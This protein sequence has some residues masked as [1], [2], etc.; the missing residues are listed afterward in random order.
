MNLPP[1][2]AIVSS[3]PPSHFADQQ[4]AA[5]RKRGRGPSQ[6]HFRKGWL[7]LGPCSQCAPQHGS[8]LP[9]G[10]LCDGRGCE[11]QDRYC[12]DQPGQ[13]HEDVGCEELV[14]LDICDLPARE[15]TKEEESEKEENSG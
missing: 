4:R 6:A 12:L 2:H 11:D 5:S 13:P 10:G 9:L 7:K 3:T 14:A 8:L 15:E 1:C